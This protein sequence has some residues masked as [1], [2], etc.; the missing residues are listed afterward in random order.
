[1]RSLRAKARTFSHPGSPVW[2]RT[3]KLVLIYS[4]STYLKSV[5]ETSMQVSL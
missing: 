1:M 2:R 5:V 3:M 4:I